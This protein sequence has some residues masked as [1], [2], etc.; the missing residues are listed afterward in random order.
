MENLKKAL[1]FG[2]ISYLKKTLPH[3]G[4]KF[5]TALMSISQK[6]TA[7]RLFLAEKLIGMENQQPSHFSQ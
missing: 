7:K 4:M 2:Q 3:F 1:T 6:W 5:Q